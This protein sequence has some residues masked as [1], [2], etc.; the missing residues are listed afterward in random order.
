MAK[1]W[2][3]RGTLSDKERKREKLQN[4][5]DRDEERRK[6]RLGIIFTMMR[7]QTRKGILYYDKESRRIALRED[8]TGFNELGFVTFGELLET[9]GLSKG[10]LNDHLKF[11]QSKGYL[12]SKNG[13]YRIN[14]EFGGD[15]KRIS[16]RTVTWLGSQILLKDDRKVKWNNPRPFN[17][18][19]RL[20]LLDE[21]YERFSGEI[22]RFA[23]EE[24][25][26]RGIDL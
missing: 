19:L 15:F 13:V 9:A 6:N 24:K 16:E 5:G 8:K 10:V 4:V 21:G 12:F 2:K 22:E 11:L 18:F 20:D 7:I 3:A 17:R 1:A 25:R 14:P 26:S 23:N